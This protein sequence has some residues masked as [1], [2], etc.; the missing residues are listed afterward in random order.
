[1]KITLET[2]DS[3]SSSQPNE[4]LTTQLN[5]D[6]KDKYSEPDWHEFKGRKN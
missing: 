1:M 2:L 3:L 6:Q 4:L 5:H